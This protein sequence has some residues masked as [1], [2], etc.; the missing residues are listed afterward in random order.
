VDMVLLPDTDS[1]TE[2]GKALPRD[3]A[4]VGDLL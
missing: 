4:A 2:A 3:C 1:F